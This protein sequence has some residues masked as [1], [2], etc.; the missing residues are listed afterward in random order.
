[1][2]LLDRGIN[3]YPYALYELPVSDYRRIAQ[4]MSEMGKYEK[5]Q[6]ESQGG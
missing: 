3:P 5:E 4:I 1:V 2:V 6:L